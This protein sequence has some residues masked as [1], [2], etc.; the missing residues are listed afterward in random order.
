MS[1]KRPDLNAIK[2]RLKEPD[3]TD[4]PEAPPERV[5]KPKLKP[6]T[7]AQVNEFAQAFAEANK[8]PPEEPSVERT[9]IDIVPDNT[10]LTEEDT[11]LDTVFYRNTTY[12]N[13]QVR[14]EIESGCTE[15]DFADLVLTGRVVQRVPILPGRFGVTFQSLLGYEDFWV[16]SNATSYSSDEWSSQSWMGYARLAMSTID[17]NG[18]EMGNH[19]K[20]GAVDRDL[21]EK[22]FEVLM[23]KGTRLLEYMLVNLNWF[24]DREKQLWENDFELLKN[25]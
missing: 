22:K 16:Q 3:E 1:R 11:K 23:S 5:K 10:S 21:F 13:K 14:K 12:D 19:S 7:A 4:V 8:P 18:T 20:N 2:R 24:F 15:M 9:E 17:I 25:G 6:E